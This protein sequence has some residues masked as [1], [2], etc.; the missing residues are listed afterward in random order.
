MEYQDFLRTKEKSFISSGFDIDQSKLN[1]ILFDFQKKFQPNNTFGFLSS[2]SECRSQ[3]ALL[4]DCAG[5][6]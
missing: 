2:F 3:L 1:P 5:V 6:R 4:S